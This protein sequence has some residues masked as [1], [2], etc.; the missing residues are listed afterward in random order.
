GDPGMALNAYWWLRRGFARR[1]LHHEAAA[2]HH[3][4]AA[5]V[6]RFRRAEQIDRAGRLIGRAGTPERNHPLHR[7]HEV[8]VHADLDLP[9]FDIDRCALGGGS[10]REAAAAPTV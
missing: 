9:A 7:L 6:V 2:A 1:T 8:R 10:A 3:S 5:D 4:L